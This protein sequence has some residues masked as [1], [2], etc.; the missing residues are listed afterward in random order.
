MTS[1]RNMAKHG[2]QGQYRSDQ[3]VSMSDS[4]VFSLT[5]KGEDNAEF[6]T[7]FSPNLKQNSLIESKRGNTS[8]GICFLKSS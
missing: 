5:E 4:N 1:T 3:F 7:I 8:A 2:G 6:A